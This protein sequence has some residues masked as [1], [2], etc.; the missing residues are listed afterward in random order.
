MTLLQAILLGIVQGLTEFIPVSSSAHLVIT[1]MLLRWEIP[2]QQAF[3]FD[4]LVQL[5]TL[6]AVIAYFW[7]DLTQIA[8]AVLTG[9]V[10]RKPFADSLSRLGWLIVLATIPAGIF[11]VLIQ[12]YVEQ[13]FGS[14]LLTGFFLLATAALLTAAEKFGERIRTLEQ[15][16]WVDALWIGCFQALAVFP[17]ISRSGATIS[18]GML[19]GVDRPSAARFS[20]LLSIPIM[21]AAGI[22]SITD[23]TQVSSF[24]SQV[25]ALLAGFIAAAVTGYLSIR[26]LLKYLS[27]RS[28][29]IFAIYC[30]AAGILTII[31]SFVL[32]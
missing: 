21:L 26:W 25:P 7:R 14:P 11:G 2:S 12:D 20:F 32:L 19:K 24:S 9:L 16:T 1:P 10:Q 23:L 27:H 4:V 18:G 15:L 28:F 5:G 30:A 22:F 6:V 3:N 17:G 13:A 31:L 29:Y 8:R